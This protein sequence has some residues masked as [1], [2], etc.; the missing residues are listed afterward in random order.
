M[1]ILKFYME[2]IICTNDDVTPYITQSWLNFIN[3][4]E[5]H[6]IHNHPNSFIS[7][8]IYIQTQPDIDKIFFEKERGPEIICDSKELNFFNTQSWFFPVDVGDIILFPSSLKHYVQGTETH[9]RISLAFNSF[10]H[11]TLCKTSYLA[12]LTV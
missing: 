1:N 8:V 12:K 11:G 10:L 9:Q 6:H 3:P 2:N 7:G 4:N 5:F